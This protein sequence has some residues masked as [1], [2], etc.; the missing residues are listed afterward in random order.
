MRTCNYI[1]VTLRAML[2]EAQR[3]GLVGRNVAALVRPF[4]DQREERP[5]SVLTPRQARILLEAAQEDREG[6][7]WVLAIT[8]GLRQGELAGLRWED[9]DLEVRRLQVRRTLQYQNGLGWLEQKPKTV[10]SRRT[11]ALPEVAM[12]AL[13]RQ[14][15]RQAEERRAAGEAWSQEFGDLV[16]RN[17][18]GRQ[19]TSSTVTK[20]F[21]RGLKALGLPRVPFHALRH[22]AASLLAAQGLSLRSVAEVLGH[23]QISTTAD[24]YTHVFETAQR[25]AAAAM[26][27]AL[28]G[29]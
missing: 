22:S 11:L 16:F 5:L 18:W 2:S 20:R 24:L 7:L 27:R 14:Q 4:A 23:A 28:G 10:R 12:V 26:D 29:N 3:D 17:R 6:P 19:E 25:E 21:Q 15:S 8:T 1:R 9:V 13:N